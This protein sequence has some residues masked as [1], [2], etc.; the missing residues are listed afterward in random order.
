MRAALVGIIV[1]LLVLVGAFAIGG[2]A[3]DRRFGPKVPQDVGTIALLGRVTDNEDERIVVRMPD[4]RSRTLP[5]IDPSFTVFAPR[6]GITA[7]DDDLI[8]EGVVAEESFTLIAGATS[9]CLHA[10]EFDYGFDEAD[11]VV[12]AQSGGLGDPVAFRLPK[13]PAFRALDRPDYQN[14]WYD[15]RLVV[16]VNVAGEAVN[17]EL[18]ST[19]P[20]TDEIAVSRP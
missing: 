12:G 17:A 1:A 3:L 14:R 16:C 19:L 15:Y 11:A 8:F 7:E 10:I 20:V 2:Y 13:A 5:A 4:G 9:R 6:P 18:F